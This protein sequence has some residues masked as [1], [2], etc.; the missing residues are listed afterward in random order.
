MN[1]AKHSSQAWW[2]WLGSFVLVMPFCASLRLLEYASI[3][4]VLD[5]DHTPAHCEHMSHWSR[6]FAIV[7]LH[8]FS[9]W[10]RAS[11]PSW[12]F[13]FQVSAMYIHA[14]TT[15]LAERLANCPRCPYSMVR[16]LSSLAPSS[17]VVV[18]GLHSLLSAEAMGRMTVP[19]R[20]S[21]FARRWPS[22]CATAQMNDAALTS[23]SVSSV[24]P[25]SAMVLLRSAKHSP[26]VFPAVSVV[27][28]PTLSHASVISSL[29][30]VRPALLR[31]VKMLTMASLYESRVHVWSS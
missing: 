1:L 18:T 3:L 20:R 19:L 14:Q 26:A 17:K 30:R 25:W 6:Y 9:K 24:S 15:A 4:V 29:V 27:S 10:S 5:P 21:L 12:W 2:A 13:R 7:S 22:L 31:R 28:Q 16:W 11:S 8:C 23:S